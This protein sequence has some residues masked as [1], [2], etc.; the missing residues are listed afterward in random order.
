MKS[1]NFRALKRRLKK[2]SARN[3]RMPSSLKKRKAYSEVP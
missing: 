3:A 1:R 2:F